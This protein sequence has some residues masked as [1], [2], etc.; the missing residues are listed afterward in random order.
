MARWNKQLGWL[1]ALLL[2]GSVWGDDLPRSAET[3]PPATTATPPA[4]I[5][6]ALPPRWIGGIPVD[7]WYLLGEDGRPVVIPDKVSLREYL[8]WREAEKKRLQPP[9]PYSVTR[10]ACTG[11]AGDEWVRL[12]VVLQVQTSAADEWVLI[13]LHMAEATL[14]DKVVYRGDGETLQ[15]PYHPETGYGWWIK[16]NKAN[17]AHELTLTLGVPVRRQTPGRR[18]QLSLP[19]TAVSSLKLRVP[20]A[21]VSAKGNDK[22]ILEVRPE[23]G[24]SEILVEGLGNRLDLFW[25]PLPDA[26]IAEAPLEVVTSVT[27]TLSAAD[28]SAT[29]EATQRIQSLGLQGMF[30]EV[31][32]TLPTGS[33][34]RVDGPEYQ[35]HRDDSDGVH[36]VVVKFKRATT[37]PVD[38]R[39]TVRAPLPA[40]GE[41]FMLEGFDV[42]R[43]RLHTGILA[44][45]V[46]GD[47]RLAALPEESKSM[48]RINLAEL[49]PALRQARTAAAYRF[50]NNRLHLRLTLHKAAPAV[51]VTPALW[52]SV[53][54]QGLELSASYQLQ[55]LRGSISDLT[56]R[57]PGWKAAG[58]VVE[59]IES[60]GNPNPQLGDE[61]AQP[62]LLRVDLAEAA[63]RQVE[64]RLRARR[65][66]PDGTSS[67]PLALPV[68]E[69]SSR[70]PTS[71][72]ILSPESLSV[73]LEPVGGTVLRPRSE[74][75]LR[76]AVPRDLQH[77]RRQ[78]YRVES[79]DA[80]FNVSLATHPREITTTTVVE[81]SLRS[82]A[83]AIRQRLAY[84]V[85]YDSLSQVRLEL[86]EGFKADQVQVTDDDA[87]RLA[88][89]IVPETGGRL[90]Q[91]SLDPPRT[92]SFEIEVRYALPLAGD[93]SPS[94]EQSVA[95]PLAEARDAPGSA[96]RLRWRD[97]SGRDVLL[98]GEGWSRS[99]DVDGSWSW[100]LPRGTTRI[101]LMLLKATGAWRGAAVSRALIHSTLEANG[102]IRSVAEYRLTGA[103]PELMIGFPP[104]MQPRSVRSNHRELKFPA[105][106][107][108]SAGTARYRFVL[109]RG[110]GSESLLTVETVMPGS[111][112]ARFMQTS[113]ILAP[114]LPDNLPVLECYWQVTLPP[115]QHLFLDP[116]GFS[117]EFQWRRSGVFWSRHP[118]QDAAALASWIGRRSADE[119]LNAASSGNTYLFGHSGAP[120]SLRV[121]AMSRS[122]IVLVGA[123]TALLLGMILVKWP[124]TR[125][126]LTLLGAGFL[127]SLAAV[128]FSGPVLVLLQPAVLGIVLALMAAIL[129][130]MLKRRSQPMTVTLASP[131]G[132]MTPLSSAPR[133]MVVAVGSNEHT[134]ARA[135]AAPATASAAPAVGQLSESG[136]RT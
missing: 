19:A 118:N 44:I 130:G 14:R 17:A 67:V 21:R 63:R 51:A 8:E 6:P 26:T 84:D 56:F 62:D 27:A 102:A 127:V 43:A 87:N 92:G 94:A 112:A 11:D 15:A 31:R 37:G 135:P 71:L 54:A 2:A 78:G 58:W 129:D 122:A 30:D 12:K 33:D 72:M 105:P 34:F 123:G 99:H 73:A 70:S 98:E 24:A 79:T 25:Q 110:A 88:S 134:S 42:E 45:A 108:D 120:E 65:A 131:S 76:V 77:L 117:S 64:L 125:H 89:R 75:T 91:V 132:F 29:L 50:L 116:E 9:V 48:Q 81:A 61:A 111:S 80:L 22:S 74:A 41:P 4:T 90:L 47:Y 55:V 85:S 35:E 83:I 5:G 68:A 101:D 109:E 104:G 10:V 3:G 28:K 7:V 124:A 53:D 107:V 18:M 69:A 128:W 115:G 1:A 93:L 96:T 32:V 97:P 126:V 59:S 133:A 86:P 40:V 136:S 13:P 52:L 100:N 46:Q 66:L 103:V 16:G 113:Q 57:W 106:Q 36:R 39:W 82:G 49:P 60:P 38:L 121:R 114:R 23:G 119:E 20:H 95:I